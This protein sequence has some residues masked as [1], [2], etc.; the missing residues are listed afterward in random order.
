[1]SSSLVSLFRFIGMKT[2]IN[3]M[4]FNFDSQYMVVEILNKFDIINLQQSLK[5]LGDIIMWTYFSLELK[6]ELINK[7]YVI[8]LYQ[9]VFN[10]LS[11]YIIIYSYINE[12]FFII[13]SLHVLN[14][15]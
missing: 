13:I 9:L 1:M 14:I 7:L 10:E 3:S 2:N 12:V 4:I 11:I 6:N 8:Q 15:N 5:R